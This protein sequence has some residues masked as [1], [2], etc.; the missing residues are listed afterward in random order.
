VSSFPILPL[1]LTA[2]FF[3]VSDLKSMPKNILDPCW[4]TRLGMWDG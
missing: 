2:G 3:V 4:E 1:H